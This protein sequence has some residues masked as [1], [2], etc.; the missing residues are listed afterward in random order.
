ME[1]KDIMT[2]MTSE[3]AHDRFKVKYLRAKTELQEIENQIEAL[4]NAGEK[5]TESP[6]VDVLRARKML[7]TFYVRNFE[8]A[9]K[10]EN[11]E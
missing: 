1:L 8:R 4:S 7:L 3:N 5:T 10:E 6:S 2:M 11:V 9:M